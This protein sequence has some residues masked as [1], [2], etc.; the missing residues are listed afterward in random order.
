MSGLSFES[1]EEM[2]AAWK[3]HRRE[4]RA[5]WAEENPPGTRCFAEWA[6]EIAPKFGERRM[7]AAGA[8]IVSHRGAWERHG[9]LHTHLVP[10]AQEPEAVFLFRNG[11]IDR[12][13]YRAARARLR[14]VR[15]VR[16]SQSEN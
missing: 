14:R 15:T 9:I 10:A 16:A 8:A 11:I 7:T 6:F 13:E 3:L 12:E 1:E 4:L 5:K 2:S